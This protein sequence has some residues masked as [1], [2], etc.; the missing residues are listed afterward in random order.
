[1]LTEEH[2]LPSFFQLHLQ[3]SLC[4]YDSLSSASNV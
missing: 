2:S 3:V 1:M 4:K